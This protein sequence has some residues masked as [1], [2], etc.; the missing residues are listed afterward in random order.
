ML[1]VFVSDVARNGDHAQHKIV[2]MVELINHIHGPIIEYSCHFSA[3][4]IW[5]A[6]QYNAIFPKTLSRAPS[7]QYL[8]PPLVHTCFLYLKKH[9]AASFFS[10]NP[11]FLYCNPIVLNL[12]FQKLRLEI[13]RSFRASVDFKWIE[14]VEG[15]D[16]RGFDFPRVFFELLPF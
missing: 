15:W 16:L 8:R 9:N 12:H 6:A 3:I 14:I 5:I 4:L 13:V 10:S 11:N 7:A 1:M 2:I